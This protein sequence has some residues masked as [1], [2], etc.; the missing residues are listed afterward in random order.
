MVSPPRQIL[1]SLP[2]AMTKVFG[3]DPVRRFPEWFAACDPPGV[4]FGSGGGV[5]HILHEDWKACGRPGKFEQWVVEFPKL[6]ML[7]GGQSRRLPA[8][9]PVGKIFTPMPVLR[10]SLGQSID[11]TLLDFMLPAFERVLEA[12]D[13]HYPVMI[14]SGDVV[15]NF[16]DRLPEFP[17]ADVLGLGMWV[18]PETASDFGVFFSRREA[19]EALSFFKQ[20]PA[21][22]VIREHSS[23]F[24]CMVDTGTW[25]L[26]SKALQVLLGQCGWNSGTQDFDGGRPASYEIYAGFGPALGEMP[27][28]P[29]PVISELSAVVTPLT[30]AEF[31]HLGTSRQMIES[32]SA[33]QNSRLDQLQSGPMDR[34]PHPDIYVLNADFPF[35]KR[36]AENHHIWIENSTLP[37]DL[38]LAY[39]HVITGV[40]DLPLTLEL[41]PGTCLDFAPMGEAEF[42]VRAYGFDDAFSGQLGDPSTLWFGRP[43]L[44]WFERREIS[45]SEAGLEAG[46][47]IQLAKIFPVV[48]R[49]AITSGFLAWL[50][51]M[52]PVAEAGHR[53]LFLA[54]RLSAMEI[55]EFCQVGRLEAQRGMLISRTLPRMRA[56]ARV[57]PF[58]RLDL[59]SA[60]RLF[61]E[62]ELAVAE[63]RDPMIAVHDAM[64][65]AEVFKRTESVKAAA[66]E[67]EAFQ[68]LA[69]AIIHSVRPLL[70]RPTRCTLDDQIVWG[71]SPVRLD[72]AGGWSD[73]PPYCFKRG[74]G[75]VNLAVDVNG[76]PPIQVFLK[77]A[78]SPVIVLKSIDL[79]VE[80]RIGTYDELA[81]YA[82]PGSGFALAK[83]ALCLAGF[84]PEFQE[85]FSFRSLRE[86]L[87]ALGGGL[88]ISLLAAA[89]KGSG[90]GTSSILA[91]TLLGAVSNACGLGWDHS[92]IV[93]LT[94][95]VEQMLTT[96]G[97]W[98]DQ[99]GAIYRGIKFLET[100]PGLSQQ[101]SLRWLPDH[102]FDSANALASARLY[103]TGITRMASGILREIVRGMFLNSRTH[104]SIVGDIRRNAD[105]TFEALLHG[106][107]DEVSAAV[108]RSWKLNC[109]LDAGTNPAPIEDIFRRTA[110]FTAGA[111]LLGAGGG[112]YAL[113]LAKDDEAARRIQRELE[114]S[115]PNPSARFVDFSVSDLGLQITRS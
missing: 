112:G 72:L 102:L 41:R 27:T 49:D 76:Q 11:G 114:S 21:P 5:V 42:C 6:V 58:Y 31:Y 48:P 37:A 39:D 68:I 86:Q 54:S 93:K 20:K 59:L 57:N 44:E 79:G 16:P 55:S 83:A 107:W 65:R 73:T 100:S 95:A 60:A 25:L 36:S 47:D 9:A 103:Y 92:A 45:L 34:K 67:A 74:G 77:T 105:V 14:C 98:Q 51:A 8:Y 29:D 23:D 1:L 33:L 104:L 70:G 106:Q 88:E 13:G 2:P 66:A 53:A 3:N 81:R 69:R 7:A 101:V 109:R 115:P 111:K 50:T 22:E 38:A 18:A 78:A 10:W 91:A 40:P 15:L 84:H 113:F 89:P 64:L 24:L 61:P 85:G 87:E 30:G 17:K 28:R 46:T 12:V 4:K 80:E 52:E 19:P 108:A 43:A 26:G 110:D 71:R 96:G 97:G 63:T 62:S 75:V 94:L 56:N 82:A 32:L 90:L 99:A 35:L